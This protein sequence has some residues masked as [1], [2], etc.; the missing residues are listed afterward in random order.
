MKQPAPPKIVIAPEYCKKEIL[1][2]SKEYTVNDIWDAYDEHY[3]YGFSIIDDNGRKLN[4]TEHI[5]SELNWGNWITKER[6]S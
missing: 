2:P 4:C 5:C 1:T 3:G 6:E